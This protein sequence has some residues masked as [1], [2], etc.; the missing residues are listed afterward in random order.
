MMSSPGSCISS[1]TLALAIALGANSAQAA[2][3]IELATYGEASGALS[4]EFRPSAPG[5]VV[6]SFRLLI[7][8]KPPLDGLVTWTSDVPRPHGMIMQDCP[9][10]DATG[11]EIAAC[12]LWQGVI[13]AAADDGTAGLLPRPGEAAPASLILPDLAYQLVARDLAGTDTQDIFTL[14]GCQE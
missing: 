3:P 14:N 2:C 9:E 8:G 10:G 5:A 13:Y 6:N 11:E 1:F 7:E 12:T 4:L